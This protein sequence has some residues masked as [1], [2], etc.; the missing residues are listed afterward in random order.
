VHTNIHKMKSGGEEVNLWIII[1][2]ILGGLLLLLIIALVAW[3]L[4]FF[5]RKDRAKLEKLKRQSGF[6]N[7]SNRRSTKSTKSRSS[8]TGS[9]VKEKK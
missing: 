4:G 9:S 1:G 2:G 6:Y 8:S 5:R 3:K 7:D